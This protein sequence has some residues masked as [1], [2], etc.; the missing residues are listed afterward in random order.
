MGAMTKESVVLCEETFVILTINNTGHTS[1]FSEN[2]YKPAPICCVGFFK[3][4]S[5]FIDY[6]I[7]KK[8][9]FILVLI[10]SPHFNLYS[11]KPSKKLE[12][13]H[14]FKFKFKKK[15]E[16]KLN[17]FASLFIRNPNPHAHKINTHVINFCIVMD[18]KGNLG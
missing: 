9:F 3:C 18:N 10:L 12:E 6:L 8:Q 13:E 16:R 7:E 4:S 15:M 1:T 17:T 14:F 2:R 11:S 5:L